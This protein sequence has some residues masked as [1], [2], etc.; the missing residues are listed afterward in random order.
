MTLSG[1]S[2]A[3]PWK[4]SAKSDAKGLFTAD[5][6]LRLAGPVTIRTALKTKQFEGCSERNR[7]SGAEGFEFCLTP[8]EARRNPVALNDGWRFKLDPPE[9]F[10]A[11]DFDDAD[12]A[13]IKVPAHWEM[14]GFRSDT[15]VGGY[16]L[17]FTAPTS[18]GR[19]K[20][21]FEGVYSGAEVWVNGQLVA[22]HEGG[23]TPFEA[24]ITDAV[25][26]GDNVLALRV[27]EHTTVSDKLDH[28]SLYADFP[29]AGIM[30]P[31]YLFTTPDVHLADLQITTTFD[32]EYRDAT[33]TVRGRVLNES[34]QAFRGRVALNSPQYL[35]QA[36]VA[37]AKSGRA[38][39]V[40]PW[41]SA[42]VDNCPPR[43]RPG[44]VECRAAE[45]LCA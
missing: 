3:G 16:R 12:W 36:E 43:L 22:T 34:P 14:E 19:V 42:E 44:E 21:D 7:K 23:A 26:P 25:K 4:S 5:M 28:M 8:R 9:G 45:L 11:A 10:W 13:K 27:R 1:K 41:Q 29:L 35:L 39:E 31:V 32:K 2:P 40:G 30:R 20:L 15:G 37:D 24:D 38:V 18:P 33:M 17:H 6:P